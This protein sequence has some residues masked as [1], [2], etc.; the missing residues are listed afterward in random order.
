MIGEEL[1]GW[2]GVGM[3]GEEQARYSFVYV[4]IQFSEIL[5][6]YISGTF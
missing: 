1:D 3:V 6:K 4:L 5:T 2:G